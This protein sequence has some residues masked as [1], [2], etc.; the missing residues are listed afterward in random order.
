ML[1]WTL[2]SGDMFKIVFYFA[3]ANDIFRSCRRLHANISCIYV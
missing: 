1:V 2:T 3:L